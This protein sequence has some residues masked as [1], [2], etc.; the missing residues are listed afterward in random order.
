[1]YKYSKTTVFGAFAGFIMIGSAFAAET[2]DALEGMENDQKILAIPSVEATLEKKKAEQVVSVEQ[3]SGHIGAKEQ[4]KAEDIEAEKL[5]KLKP[6]A[7]VGIY[8]PVDYSVFDESTTPEIAE[9]LRLWMEGNDD[10]ALPLFEELL[11][12]APENPI[13]AY[14][15][16]ISAMG[17]QYDAEKL[18]GRLV[19]RFL[20]QTKTQKGNSYF[21][22]HADA[23][24]QA[25]EEFA[26]PRAQFLYGHIGTFKD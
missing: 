17:G 15:L 23:I 14:I 8:M 22:P 1:M 18:N 4:K 3:L 2:S 10:K 12:K 25:A 26:L 21:Y 19:N 20:A 6:D 7:A 5:K 16:T 9:A 11:E 13:P 24:K